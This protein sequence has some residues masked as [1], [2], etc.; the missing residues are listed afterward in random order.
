MNANMSSLRINKGLS[1]EKLAY[2]V[3]VSR[4]T[5][6]NIETGF[7]EPHVRLAMKIA[8][9]LGTSVDELFGDY[10]RSDASHS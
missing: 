6:C 8:K 3:G 9:T 7:A 4:Q 5:I 2:L 10:E 1:Q